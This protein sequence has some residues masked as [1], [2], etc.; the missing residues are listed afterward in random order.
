MYD[1]LL[2]SYGNNTPELKNYSSG[3][4]SKSQ[5][6][7][8]FDYVASATYKYLKRYFCYFAEF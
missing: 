8:L 7:M 1:E 6:V 5:L 4:I 2:C 3:Y